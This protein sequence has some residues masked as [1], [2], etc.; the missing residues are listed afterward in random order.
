MQQGARPRAQPTCPCRR[1]GATPAGARA[2]RPVLTPALALPATAVEPAHA[3][4]LAP[5]AAPVAPAQDSQPTI[6]ELGRQGQSLR[7]TIACESWQSHVGG[8]HY[9]CLV[10]PIKTGRLPGTGLNAFWNYCMY[11]LAWHAP[12][13]GCACRRVATRK[14]PLQDFWASKNL[15]S[16]FS[17]SKKKTFNFRPRPLPMP[18]PPE[19][20]PRD[21]AQEKKYPGQPER[22]RQS[23]PE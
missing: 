23:S 17:N 3:A 15:I 18:M 8:S 12:V 11:L 19:G 2:A 14:N 20:D 4:S 10:F 13:A 16:N 9:S 5:A 22:S 21:S 7:A 1:R 6:A